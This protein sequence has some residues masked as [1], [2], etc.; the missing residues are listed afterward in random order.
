MAAGAGRA[1]QPGEGRIVLPGATP[2]DGDAPWV[3]VCLEASREDG[4]LIERSRAV[5]ALRG[6]L[7]CDAAILARAL[8]KPCVVSVSE[9][10]IREGRVW[11]AAQSG[12]P[13]D[14]RAWLRVDGA[15]GE[16][17]VEPSR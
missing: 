17:L 9:L 15:T 12:S 7:T 5:L 13:L 16:V 1:A 8:G 2:P 10:M 11:I 4:P 3:F 14:D 6:G